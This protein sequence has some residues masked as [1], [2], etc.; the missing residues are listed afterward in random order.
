[1]FWADVLQTGGVFAKAK[2]GLLLLV[3]S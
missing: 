1:M 3:F 2:Q